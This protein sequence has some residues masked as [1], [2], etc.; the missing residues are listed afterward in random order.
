M[1][2]ALVVRP[3]QKVGE[4]GYLENPAAVLSVIWEEPMTTNG[5]VEH[6][7]PAPQ[8]TVVVATVPK[9]P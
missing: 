8:V 2:V 5:L 3:H 7:T 1:V 4:K 9:F 6:E